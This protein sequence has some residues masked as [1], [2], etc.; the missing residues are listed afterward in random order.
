MFFS[1]YLNG[2]GYLPFTL[3]IY[4]FPVIFILT[5]TS[6]RLCCFSIFHLFHGRK[7]LRQLI[8]HPACFGLLSA[9]SCHSG[10]LLNSESLCQVEEIL[11]LLECEFEVRCLS[12]ATDL[13]D[14]PS[15]RRIR[16]C[17]ASHDSHRELRDFGTELV[18]FL[19][20]EF[21]A[22]FVGSLCVEIGRELFGELFLH[23]RFLSLIDWVGLELPVRRLP[24][25]LYD[26]E[27]VEDDVLYL[28]R[29]L[30][31]PSI[32]LS[33]GSGVCLVISRRKSGKPPLLLLV[34]DHRAC[35]ELVLVADEGELLHEFLSKGVITFA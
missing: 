10:H 12:H 7:V 8:C 34:L 23:F 27:V 22:L 4:I 11:L 26:S 1:L 35:Y 3:F 25:Q 28:G 9:F 15:G 24:L 13:D 19:G 14:C 20:S 32:F 6:T 18:T 29:K 16:L 2:L 17:H 31:G 21:L 5:Y 30:R 33:E